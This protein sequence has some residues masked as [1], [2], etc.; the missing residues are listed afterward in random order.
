MNR[1][2]RL[3]NVASIRRLK[4]SPWKRALI[5]LFVALNF[6]QVMNIQHR[7]ASEHH[8]ILA[9]EARTQKIYIAS[10]HWNTEYILRTSWMTALLDLVDTLGR[11]NVFVSIFESGSVD[12]TELALWELDQELGQRGISR[13]IDWVNLT[14]TDVMN[15]PA[16][17]PGWIKTPRGQTQRRRIPYLANLRNRTLRDLQ[18]MHERGF[19]FDK[20]LFLN[21][22]VFTVS[23]HPIALKKA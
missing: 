4:K 16:V 23:F 21:D 13:R 6:L 12:N 11:E 8:D 17:G 10:L 9:A 3:S 18:D 19:K 1:I 15:E 20:V 14:H 2:A 7:L 5:L 22:V